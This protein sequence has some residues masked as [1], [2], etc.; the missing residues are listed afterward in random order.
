MQLSPEERKKIYEEEKARIEEEERQGVSAGGSTTGLQPNVAGLLCY[1]GVWIT[2]IIFIIIEQEDKYVRFHALQSIITF[3]TITVA[4]SVLRW[5]PFF[6]EFFGVVI[7]ILAFFL[8]IFLMVKAYR[9][10]LYRLP[11]A[12]QIAESILPD[13]MR[14]GKAETGREREAAEPQRPAKAEEPPEPPK[15][16][17]AQLAEKAEDLGR[18]AEDLGRRVE[19]YFTGTR[20]GRVAGYSASIFWNVVLLI[21]LSA[22]YKYVAWYHVEANGSVTRLPLLTGD[23]LNWLPI[24][25]TALVITIIAN[26]LLI[27]Y[28]SYWMREVVQ[29]ILAVI[30]VIVVANLVAVFPFDFSVIPNNT[31]ADILPAIVTITLIFIAVGLGVGALVKFIK[32][33]V[34]ASREIVS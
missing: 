10:E 6:G 21:F 14:G 25:I 2:G 13:T 9:G 26:V 31:A 11:L 19:T 27:I 17:A 23:Y 8:W 32:L 12:G 18:R 22:F 16:P 3:G 30:G 29:I 4:G 1:L 20:A 28:D 34:N 15:A 24:L 5:I 7:G 33:I